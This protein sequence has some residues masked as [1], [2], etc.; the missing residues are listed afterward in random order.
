MIEPPLVPSIVPHIAATLPGVD[1]P[2][3]ALDPDLDQLEAAIAGAVT[4]ASTPVIHRFTPGIYQREIH[5][6][7]GTLGTTMIH[8]VEHPFILL[9]G[10]LRVI[11]DAEGATTW[12]APHVGIT[13][14]GTRRALFA[15]TDCTLITFHPTHDTDVAKIVATLTATPDNPLI[16]ADSPVVNHWRHHGGALELTTAAQK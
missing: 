13:R 12:H 5:I 2:A 15:E 9:R 4:P 6:P 8:L 3:R 11:S 14:A 16:P 10:S 1:L 7:A